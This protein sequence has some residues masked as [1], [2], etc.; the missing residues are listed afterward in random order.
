MVW[1]TVAR[2]FRP[3][4]LTHFMFGLYSGYRTEQIP[5]AGLM[6][7]FPFHPNPSSTAPALP[8]LGK[9]RSG[10]DGRTAKRGEVSHHI[11]VCPDCAG[12]IVRSSGCINCTQ[13]G[14]GQC[15]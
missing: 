4:F 7:V 12:P 1:R 2:C 9:E 15:G 5:K 11:R 3:G 8:E 10:A 6:S 13:C 14:W